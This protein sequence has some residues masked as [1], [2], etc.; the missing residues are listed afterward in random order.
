MRWSN[1]A[2]N[3][4]KVYIF[5]GANICECCIKESEKKSGTDHFIKRIKMNGMG[6]EKNIFRIFVNGGD[7]FGDP[8][9]RACPGAVRECNVKKEGEKAFASR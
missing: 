6:A 3:L 7:M 8:V 5:D 9:D 2:T 1:P 4:S